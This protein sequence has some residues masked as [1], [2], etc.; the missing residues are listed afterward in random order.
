MDFIA[1]LR[2]STGDLFQLNPQVDLRI[3]SSLSGCQFDGGNR[4]CLLHNLSSSDRLRFADGVSETTQ[5]T[6]QI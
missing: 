1:I 6:T 4:D 5:N 2:F 3:S